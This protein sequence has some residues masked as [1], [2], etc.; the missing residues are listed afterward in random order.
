M[1]GW[2]LTMLSRPNV[3][4]VPC[5]LKTTVQQQVHVCKHF[6]PLQLTSINTEP[7]RGQL[8]LAF[9]VPHAPGVACACLQAQSVPDLP[10]SF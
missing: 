8:W 7:H 5:F 9:P 10:L 6:S 1:D 4:C 3:G 2:A